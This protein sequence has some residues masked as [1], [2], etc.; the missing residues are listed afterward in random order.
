MASDLEIRQASNASERLAF[1]KMPWRIYGNDPLWVAPLISD[2]KKY[3]NPKRGTF[4]EYGEAELF[5]A[6]RDGE[7]VGRISAQVNRRHDELFD[8]AKGFFIRECRAFCN[9]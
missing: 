5:V 1:I 3:L 6:Y 2:Q 4:F 9:G 7:A 8:E